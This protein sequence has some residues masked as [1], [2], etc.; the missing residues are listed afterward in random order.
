MTTMRELNND[1]MSGASI[2]LYS[3]ETSKAQCLPVLLSGWYS[4][5]IHVLVLVASFLMSRQQNK[6]SRTSIP[7]DVNPEGALWMHSMILSTVMEANICF[8]KTTHTYTLTHTHT[9]ARIRTDNFFPR[10][11]EL[12]DQGQGWQTL[13]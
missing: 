4:N 8:A 5:C 13:K 12:Q 10:P 7:Q 1:E 2:P 11:N 3:F 9:H 6:A